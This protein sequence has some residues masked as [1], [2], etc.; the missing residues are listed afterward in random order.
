MSQ[1]KKK[2]TE[3]SETVTP[4]NRRVCDQSATLYPTH[5]ILHYT[6]LLQGFV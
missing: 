1:K 4:T 3:D 6:A 5:V 2:K